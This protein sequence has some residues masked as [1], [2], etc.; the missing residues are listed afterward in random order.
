M[1]MG[2][3][4][5]FCFAIFGFNFMLQGKRKSTYIK[6]AEGVVKNRAT[7]VLLSVEKQ[8]VNRSRRK[9]TEYCYGGLT[10]SGSDFTA[11]TLKLV[12]VHSMYYTLK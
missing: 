2:H 6:V 4:L 12:R 5:Q 3:A 1:S 8:P 9:S 10:S 11:K 7:T